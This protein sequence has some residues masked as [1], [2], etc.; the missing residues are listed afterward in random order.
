MITKY[1]LVS[2]THS[3]FVRVKVEDE[4]NSDTPERAWQELRNSRRFQQG[5]FILPVSSFIET[6]K[7]F[8]VAVA[9]HADQMFMNLK[10][11]K[12]PESEAPAHP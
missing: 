8:E 12:P 5:M 7:A 4:I 3:H 9:D 11:D 10:R 2:I 6:F 1:L